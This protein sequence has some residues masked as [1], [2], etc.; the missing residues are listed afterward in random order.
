[1]ALVFAVRSTKYFRNTFN[2]SKIY[3]RPVCCLNTVYHTSHH[4]S[5]ADIFY[6]PCRW[7]NSDQNKNLSSLFRP[8]RA[9]PTNKNDDN[10][11]A[12]LSGTLNKGKYVT[13]D[14]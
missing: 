5:S 2:V 11:G 6:L 14:Y 9:S 4:R 8:L 10:T 3:H 1:M 7:K 12:E 13:F